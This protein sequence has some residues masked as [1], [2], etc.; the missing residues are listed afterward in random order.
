MGLSGAPVFIDLAPSRVR[1]SSQPDRLVEVAPVLYLASDV[2]T[3]H[4]LAVGDRDVVT[5]PAIRIQLFSTEAPPPHPI[6]KALCL[7]LFFRFLIATVAPPGLFSLKPPVI[8]RG[9]RSLTSLLAGY[10]RDLLLQTLKDAGARSVVFQD[11]GIG[12]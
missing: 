5:R 3:P 11:D 10:E 4:V 6:S 8:V 12:A 9:A 2:S 7:T 1:V